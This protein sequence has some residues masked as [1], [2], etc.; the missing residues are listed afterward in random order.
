MNRFKDVAGNE[1]MLYPQWVRHYAMRERIND[2]VKFKVFSFGDIELPRN[3]LFHYLPNIPGEVGPSNDSPF[4]NTYP[5][6]INMHFDW[7]FDKVLEKTGMRI[8]PVNRNQIEV[9]YF[10]SHFN[11][12]RARQIEIFLP[13]E[14]ELMVNNLAPAMLNVV[15]VRRTVFTPFVKYYNEMQTLINSVNNIAELSNRHQFFELKLPNTFPSYQELKQAYIHYQKFFNEENEIVKYKKEALKLFQASK[16]FWLLDLYALLLGYENTKFSKFSKFS[17]KAK[18]KTS[19]IFSYDGKCVICNIKTLLNLMSLS[20]K[21]DDLKTP[22]LRINY[23]K[24]FYLNLI[25]LVTNGDYSV[26]IDGD[27][28]ER[29]EKIISKEHPG[30]DNSS[31]I[32]FVDDVLGDSGEISDASVG[33]RTEEGSKNQDRNEPSQKGNSTITSGSEIVNNVELG[34]TEET[35]WGND[36][37]DEI[38]EQLTFS[39]NQILATQE[40]NEYSPLNAI[41]RILDQRAK[42]GKLTNK[43]KEYFLEIASS[44]KNIEIGGKTIEEIIDI[45]PTDMVM[46]NPIIAK[47]SETII[48]KSVLKSRVYDLNKGYLENIHNRNIVEM[49]TYTQNGGLCITDVTVEPITT[50]R[51]KYDVWTVNVQPING[52]PSKRTFSV[53]RVEEDGTFTINGVKSYMQLQRAEKPVRKISPTTVQLTSYYDKPRIIIERSKRVV[54]DYARDLRLKIIDA[55]KYDRTIKVTLGNYVVNKKGVCYYYSILASRFKEF[56][57]NGYDFIFDTQ[58]VVGKDPLG[59]ELC[60]EESWVVGKT[61]DGYLTIDNTGMV[62]INNQD[63]IGYIEHMFNIDLKKSPLPVATININGYKFPV[64]VVLSY[65]VGFN[66][67][68]KMLNVEYRIAEPNKRI[69]LEKDEYVISLADEK[70]IFNRRDEFNTLIISGLRK[71]KNIA[72]YSRS[73]LDD[74]NTW[75]SLMDDPKVKP[76]HFKEMG[77]IYD[78]YIDPITKRLLEKDNYPVVMDQLVIAALKLLLTEYSPAETELTEQRFIGYERFSG[79][80]YR[81]WCKAIRQLRNKPMGGKRTLDLNPDAI[82]LKI[83]TDSSVQ[84]VEEV[85]PIHQLKQQEE[86]TNGGTLGRAEKAMVRRTRG[87]HPNSIGIVSEAGK[88]SSKVGFIGYLTV[89]PKIVDYYGNVDV[90]QNATK[91]GLGSVT[92]N[93]LYGGTRDDTKRSNLFMVSF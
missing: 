13:K 53:P 85:N 67:L 8:K 32:G 57:I 64:V 82:M 50:A 56:K 15:Y 5:A 93:T 62:M 73:Y 80:I 29:E 45:K 86:Y 75:F 66:N 25:S 42:E 76:T 28:I 18:E 72:D 68:L 52:N 90:N 58:S 61:K 83:I 10:K 89:D 39:D 92:L 9:S 51:S 74:P 3:S 12:H 35:S 49:I 11:Y 78:M 47:D 88:D 26:I 21:P 24:R 46:K 81:E 34:N 23:F 48:D 44:Y 69:E 87:M 6:R 36:I 41:N 84:A 17:D 63:P 59:I 27:E 65:W 70:L 1:V 91:S 30:L 79:H 19:F 2:I 43:E 31:G 16:S 54:D 38:F 14:I 71:I 22:S 20:D 55:A 40:K 77:Q 37:P 60:N 7:K 33:W 4:L